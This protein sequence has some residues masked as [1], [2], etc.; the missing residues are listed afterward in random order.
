M[1]P[2][3]LCITFRGSEGRN[4][5]DQKCCR[6]SKRNLAHE[7]A[8]IDIHEPLRRLHSL[9]QKIGLLKLIHCEQ[10]QTDIGREIET[11]RQLGSNR[12][13]GPSAFLE[14]LEH[15]RRGGI[16]EMH[17][18]V[19]LIVD[20]RL[21]VESMTEQTSSYARQG[22]HAQYRGYRVGGTDPPRRFPKL[23]L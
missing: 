18:I 1:T 15:T 20:Q 4:R 16:E 23:H 11:A 21:T 19:A 14:K 22:F 3:A 12:L 6:A 13:R 10:K 7:L 17:S 9:V 5:R 2:R 8:T